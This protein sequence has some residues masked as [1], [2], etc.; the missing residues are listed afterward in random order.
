MSTSQG[1]K[2]IQ[3]AVVGG[4]IGGLCVALGLLK[5]PHLEVQIYEA[6]HKFSEIGAGVAFGPNAQRALKLIGPELEQ[7][8]LNQATHNQWKDMANTWFEYEFGMGPFVG[9][10]IVAPK[11]ETGQAT[12]HRAKFLQEFV[13]LLPKGIAHFGKRMHE[14]KDNGKD[15]VDI[16]FKDGTTAHADCVIGADGVHSVTRRFLLGDDDRATDAIFSTSVA[17]RGEERIFI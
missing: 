4:G 17:Y 10:K 1:Q 5:H 16:L 7:A 15:G 13:N 6:A 14:I 2:K 11:N 9:E 12:V 3:V 8:Y